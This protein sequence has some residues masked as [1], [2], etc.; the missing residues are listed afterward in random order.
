[1]I[2][3]ISDEFSTFLT[4]S[5]RELGSQSRSQWQLPEPLCAA[6]QELH[7][8]RLELRAEVEFQ[9]SPWFRMGC[10]TVGATFSQTLFLYNLAATKKV[11]FGWLVCLFFWGLIYLFNG[12]KSYGEGKTER[13][14]QCT[15]SVS[16]WPP[17]L[18]LGQ[19]IARNPELLPGAHLGS[20]AASVSVLLSCFSWGIGSRHRARRGTAALQVAL[21]ALPWHRRRDVLPSWRPQTGMF[22]SG[23]SLTVSV[24]MDELSLMLCLW[25]VSVI[26]LCCLLV[27]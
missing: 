18:G 25:R 14:I 13:D 22:I 16:M 3:H 2:L 24:N 23:A 1:M 6:R 4:N 26:F 19:A 27:V 11:V 7:Q 15:G 9:P 20:R 21:R 12:R 8:Q 5:E 17:W 10:L